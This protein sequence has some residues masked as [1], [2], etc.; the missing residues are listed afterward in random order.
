[1]VARITSAGN[2]E[3]FFLEFSDQHHRPFH[4]AGDFFE[5]RFVLDEFEALAR[6][7][8]SFASARMISLRRS[9]SSTTRAAS[10]LC[11]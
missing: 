8:C 11:V 2:V 3:E 1:M 5:Q 6:A 4:E 9:A 7:R 10:S